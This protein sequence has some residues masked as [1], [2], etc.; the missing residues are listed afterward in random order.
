MDGFL[1]SS[2]KY[3]LPRRRSKSLFFLEFTNR[4]LRNPY[5]SLRT[6]STLFRYL[7]FGCARSV[8][9]F[10]S[11]E[12]GKAA[13]LGLRWG[14]AMTLI[15]LETISFLACAFYVYVLFHWMRDTKRKRTIHSTAENQAEEKF[16][17]K[18]LHILGSS[19][20][21]GSEG[22][23]AAGSLRPA[24]MAERSRG[25]GPCGHERERNVYETIARSLS[26]GRRI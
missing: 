24:S 14:G 17:Q 21:A 13:E 3:Q 9:F 12:L 2:A 4:C 18:R 10:Q 20:A 7:V 5:K 8:E 25:S 1:E 22:R 19:R 6:S 23:F 15:I 11:T 16:E 26:L